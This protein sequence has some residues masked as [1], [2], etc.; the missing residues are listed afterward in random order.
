MPDSSRSRL[1]VTLV[2]LVVGPGAAW[3][4]YR[5]V[6][7]ERRESVVIPEPAVEVKPEKWLAKRNW[8]EN[9]PGS[10]LERFELSE[11]EARVLLPQLEHEWSR[12]D[13]RMYF[14]YRPQLDHYLPFEEHPDGGYRV[15]TNSLGMRRDTEVA[16]ERP[17]LRVLVAGDS[18]PDGVCNN[19]ENFTALAEA[20]LEARHPGRSIEVLN[21][22]RGG[23]GP[24]NYIGTLESFG[25]LE[26]HRFVLWFSGS[27]DFFDPLYL[28]KAFRGHPRSGL[29]EE[30]EVKRTR[31]RQIHMPTYTAGIHSTYYLIEEPAM[32]DYSLG[33]CEDILREV[34][35]IC[36]RDGIEPLVVFLPAPLFLPRAKPN[37]RAAE[38]MRVLE[39]EEE[40]L[41]A[42]AMHMEEQLT[43]ICETL[44]V[45]LLN[46]RS[47]LAP[48]ADE[49]F[50]EFD[51]HLNPAGHRVVSELLLGYWSELE[52]LAD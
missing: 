6:M 27:N 26:P 42:Q 25:H 28:G 22:S 20:A 48:R 16:Q 18:H 41:A 24:F 44:G 23:Q 15:V 35:L 19:A 49:C 46:L 4:A 31:A 45:P 10:T 17:D 50:Y 43:G 33:L 30:A 2:C 14:C 11:E 12:F 1:I 47:V 8:I 37:E 7:E 40:T 29:R 52:E 13:P 3:L 36:A 32:V 5:R 34:H 51:L 38:M 39:V 9:F 21:A